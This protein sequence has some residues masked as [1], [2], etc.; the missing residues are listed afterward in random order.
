MNKTG[1]NATKSANTVPHAT[2]T[3]LQRLPFARKM[4]TPSNSE[5]IKYVQSSLLN[6]IR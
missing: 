3:L 1:K 6:Q 5:F 2:L 4:A